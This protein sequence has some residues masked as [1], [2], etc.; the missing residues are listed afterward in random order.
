MFPV[1]RKLSHENEQQIMLDIVTTLYV[2]MNAAACR[3]CSGPHHAVT[4]DYER[5]HEHFLSSCSIAIMKGQW[6]KKHCSAFP[7]DISSPRFAALAGDQI[8][9]IYSLLFMAN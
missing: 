5:D 6:Q 7:N 1:C 2:Y 9:F 3:K 4:D 8:H